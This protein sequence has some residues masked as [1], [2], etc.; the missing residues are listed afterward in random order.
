[1]IS[2]VRLN[3]KDKLFPFSCYSISDARLYGPIGL[4]APDNPT[5]RIPKPSIWSL[6]RPMDITLY[7]LVY[8]DEIYPNHPS[9]SHETQHEYRERLKREYEFECEQICKKH[10]QPL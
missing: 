3:Y 6:H 5:P 4:L 2:I 1:M 9:Q 7:D 10:Y 8:A